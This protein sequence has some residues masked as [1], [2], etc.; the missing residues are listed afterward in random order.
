MIITK[1]DSNNIDKVEE[2][3]KLMDRNSVLFT[4]IMKQDI[5]AH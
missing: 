3:L 2:E 4:H 1:M 5:K